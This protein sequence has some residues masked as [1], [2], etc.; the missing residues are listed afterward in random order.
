[1]RNV[2][3]G[4]SYREGSMKSMMALLDKQSKTTLVA[5]GL[6]LV[7]LVGMVTLPMP[8]TSATKDEQERV[9]T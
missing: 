9:E 8:A 6:V 2:G 5:V 7:A 3:G 4:V 1:M